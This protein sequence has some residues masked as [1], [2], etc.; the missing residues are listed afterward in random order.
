MLLINRH[1]AGQI[2]LEREIGQGME[3]EQGRYLG[4]GREDIQPIS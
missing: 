2:P 1:I 3:A 4:E